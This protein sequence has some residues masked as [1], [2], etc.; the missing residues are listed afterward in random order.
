MHF[1]NCAALATVLFTT[2]TQNLR[3]CSFAESGLFLNFEQNEPC[4]LIKKSAVYLK[5][6]VKLFNHRLFTV[7]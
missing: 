3:L 7:L 5:Y 4:V 6:H 2:S 1:A